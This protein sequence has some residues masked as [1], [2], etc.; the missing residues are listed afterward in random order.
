MKSFKKK[1]NNTNAVGKK[2]KMKTNTILSFSL[3]N[4]I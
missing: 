1:K 4:T 3:H 2:V